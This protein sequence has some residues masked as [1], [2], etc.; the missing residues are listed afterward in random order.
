MLKLFPV[1]RKPEHSETNLTKNKE[2]LTNNTRTQQ[3][4]TA[5]MEVWMVD[6]CFNR[7]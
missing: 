6:D 5:V 3:E 7:K 1:Q 2:T 4:E